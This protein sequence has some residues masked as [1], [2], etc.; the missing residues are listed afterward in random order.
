M[1]SI[2]GIKSIRIRKRA[3]RGEKSLKMAVFS[4]FK[5]SVKGL[6]LFSLSLIIILSQSSVFSAFEA[7]VINVTAKIENRIPPPPPPEE[8]LKKFPLIA[9]ACVTQGSC[10]S[11]ENN[12]ARKTMKIISKKNSNSRIFIRFDFRFPPGTTIQSALLNLFMHKAPKASREYEARR[13]LEYWKERDPNGVTW[14]NQP[15]VNTEITSMTLSGAAP[16]WLGWNVASDT[17][18]FIDG[19]FL[20]YGWRLSDSHED[21]LTRYLAKFRSRESDQTSQRPVL[22]IAFTSPPA[23]TAY[24]VINEVYSDVEENKGQDRK[25]EWVEIYNPTGSAVDL[26]GWK[27]CASGGCDSIPS[28]SPIPS[29]G[30]AVI[31]PEGSTWGFWPDLPAEAIKI[32]LGSK[33]G[34]NGLDNLGDRVIL[35]NASN[36][37]IDAMSYG[38]DKSQLNP[39]VHVPSE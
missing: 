4:T 30:F 5:K 32:I 12:G 6:A 13:V 2:D 10:I 3:R 24:P 34:A 19:D 17:Q 29:H 28:S 8:H 37:T 15:E 39:S 20:N 27:I 33:I 14:R 18:S 21:S 1:K 35:R 26:S 22:E 36:A 31:A 23:E 38:N 9:D 16:S 7:H 11:D 25:N